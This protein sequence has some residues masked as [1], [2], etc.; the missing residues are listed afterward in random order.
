[1]DGNGVVLVLIDP[2]QQ[3]IDIEQGIL[4]FR[5]VGNPEI[6]AGGLQF[7]Q[8]KLHVIYGAK[9]GVEQPY[10]AKTGLREVVTENPLDSIDSFPEALLVSSPRWEGVIIFF[11][12]VVQHDL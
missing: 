5:I 9:K 8:T 3:F 7:R 1:V 11:V 4:Q 10:G 12:S 6:R 2:F